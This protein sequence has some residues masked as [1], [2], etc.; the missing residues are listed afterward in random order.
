MQFLIL[1]LFL[2]PH[3]LP[4]HIYNGAGSRLRPVTNRRNRLRSSL[5]K[6]NVNMISQCKG[7]QKLNSFTFVTGRQDIGVKKMIT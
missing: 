6:K 7:D 1:V 4:G 5:Q 3:L 2:V